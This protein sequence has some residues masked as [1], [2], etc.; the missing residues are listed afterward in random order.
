[1]QAIEHELEVY[2]RVH[3]V[4]CEHERQKE[5]WVPSTILMNMQLWN[6]LNYFSDH[7][8]SGG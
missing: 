2:V 8:I 3:E 5:E 6:L 1:M 4:R 7:G